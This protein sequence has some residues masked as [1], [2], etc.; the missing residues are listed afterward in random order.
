MN[1]PTCDH[2][3]T[4]LVSHNRILYAHC[5]RCGTLKVTIL[6]ANPGA[7]NPRFYVPKLVERCREF[8]RA[9]IAEI[10]ESTLWVEREWKRL[11]IA[12]SINKPEDRRPM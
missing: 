12:E 7:D 9:H 10:D 3:M 1:C 11:G 5:E 8:E 2:T 6:D 4:R